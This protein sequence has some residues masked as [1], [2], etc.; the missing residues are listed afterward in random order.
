MEMHDYHFSGPRADVAMHKSAGCAFEH[1]WDG[2]STG[3]GYIYINIC[4]I[5]SIC[6]SACSLQWVMAEGHFIIC[7]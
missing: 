7:L 1:G 6:P 3:K 2:T 4:R 5:K